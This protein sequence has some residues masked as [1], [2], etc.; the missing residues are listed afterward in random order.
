MKKHLIT[1]FIFTQFFTYAIE[2]DN[3]FKKVHYHKGHSTPMLMVLREDL[4]ISKFEA[5]SF[6]SQ[7]LN[8]KTN[9]KLIF[10][11][12][13]KD[14]LG[15]THIKYQQEINGVKVFGGEYQA[16]LKDGR[17]VKY[18]GHYFPNV[19]LEQPILSKENS[20]S[21]AMDYFGSIKYMWEDNE[22]EELLKRVKK[23]LKA[24]YYPNPELMYYNISNGLRETHFELVYEIELYSKLPIKK[25]KIYVSATTGSIVTTINGLHDAEQ[26][27]KGISKFSDTL[28]I[29]TEE[30]GPNQYELRDLS[31]GGGIETYNMHEGTNHSS[32]TIFT[33]TDTLW[34]L[35]NSSKD[36]VAI[37]AHWGAEM[38]YDYY[39]EEHN[40]DSY[41]DNGTVMLSYVH[42]SIKYQNAFWDGMRMT[43]GDGDPNPYLSID[44]VGHEMSHG[45][46]G[47]SA[48]LE[49]RGESGAL[50]ESFSDI[51]GNS[52][53]YYAN[54]LRFSWLVGEQSFNVLRDMSNPGAYSD[55]DTY[56]GSAWAST[57]NPS[58]QNDWGGV[59]TNSGVQNF[60]YYLLVEGGSGMNDNFDSYNI[61]SLGWEKSSDIAYR[62]L[63]NYLSRYSDYEDAA[64][65]AIS[66]GNFSGLK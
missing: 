7:K 62:N 46:T 8:L 58:D 19:L 2:N 26:H 64:I 12:E 54:P 43:Y 44:I 39:L 25:E 49:Y 40:R 55:P 3:D 66:A 52:I 18:T 10:I 29:V 21:I 32:S 41:D 56:E 15:F 48:N 4:Y 14:D 45:V 5:N 35:V 30:V 59:H 50:N 60:W 61:S 42:Y 51:F 63:N 34:D 36:E 17:V 57:Q 28:D 31:R 33:S 38:T 22:E 1:L 37:D 47:N 11:S 53:E 6:L 24:T 16:H 20:I 65:F 13:N 23:D 9:E 27:A